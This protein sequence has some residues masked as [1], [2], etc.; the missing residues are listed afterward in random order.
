[1]SRK[2]AK[3]FT[4]RTAGFIKRLT[5][6]YYNRMNQKILYYQIDA[7]KTDSGDLYSKHYN[8]SSTKQVK[9]P[10]LIECTVFLNEKST[11]NFKDVDYELRT[12]LDAF[13]HI[14]DLHEMNVKPSIGDIVSFQGMF[15]EIFDT[16]DHSMLHGDPEYQYGYTINAHDMR[17]ND[18]ELQLENDIQ[19]KRRNNLV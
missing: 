9:D 3:F 18:Y 11:E 1:M 10:I 16:D 5:G 4:P 12:F 13:F 17:I 6:E 2:R 8:E 7:V 14:H 19:Y 15:F